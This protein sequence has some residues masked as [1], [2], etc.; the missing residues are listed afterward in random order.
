MHDQPLPYLAANRHQADCITSL[1]LSADQQWSLVR[2]S[3]TEMN[4][5]SYLIKVVGQDE[6]NVND[7]IARVLDQKHTRV[8][9]GSTIRPR[10]SVRI[11]L[12]QGEQKVKSAGSPSEKASV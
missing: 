10:A 9:D 11:A 3:I 8:L 2:T 5:G 6:V 7:A 12:R 1:R 4:L